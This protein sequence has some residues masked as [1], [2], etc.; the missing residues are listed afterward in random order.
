MKPRDASRSLRFRGFRP[1]ILVILGLFRW[2]WAWIL[3]IFG[4][5]QGFRS[6]IWPFWTYFWGSGPGFGPY[7]W[8]LGL[9]MA[10]LGK[11]KPRDAS[12]SLRFRGCGP[13]F[14]PIWPILDLFPG[15]WAWIWGILGLFQGYWVKNWAHFGPIPGVM[16]LDLAILDLFRVLWANFG[17]FL[18]FWAWLWPFWTYFLGSEHLEHSPGQ[19]VP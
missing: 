3:A 9:E 2:L 18:G 8:V 10:I 6:W 13:R 5:F 1:W 16:G 19:P 12:Q 4:L 11:M 15:F 14:G 17:L 7:S